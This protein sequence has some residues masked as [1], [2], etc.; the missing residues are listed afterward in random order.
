M[1]PEVS[2][3]LEW[4]NFMSDSTIKRHSFAGVY[5]TNKDLPHPEVD[6]FSDLS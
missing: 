3:S 4:A 2:I 1:K 5:A 6:A